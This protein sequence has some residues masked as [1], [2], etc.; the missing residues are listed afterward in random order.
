MNYELPILRRSVVVGDQK[1]GVSLVDDFW[2]SLKEI[3]CLRDMTMRDLI[4]E[5]AARTGGGNPSS[6][7][8]LFVWAIACIARGHRNNNERTLGSSSGRLMWHGADIATAILM[9]FGDAQTNLIGK[10][11][12]LSTERQARSSASTSTK[13]AVSEWS[14]EDMTEGGRRR[15]SKGNGPAILSPSHMPS[16]PVSG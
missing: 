14:F 3:A 15:P 8:R 4:S 9:A 12:V 6:A 11:V 7:I 5:R 1:F 13:T 16:S 10:T 2:R